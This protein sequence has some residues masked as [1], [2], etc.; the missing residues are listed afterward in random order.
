MAGSTAHQGFVDVWMQHLICCL[1]S[2]IA[3]G[4]DQQRI[5]AQTGSTP[6]SLGGNNILPPCMLACD[7]RYCSD[8]PEAHAFSNQFDDEEGGSP[9]LDALPV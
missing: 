4:D 7:A 3:Q 6:V 8:I 2:I 5:A 9:S 1:V